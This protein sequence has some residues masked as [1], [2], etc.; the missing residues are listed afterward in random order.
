MREQKPLYS[1]D[2]DKE[3]L[4]AVKLIKEHCSKN[5]DCFKCIICNYPEYWEVNMTR[6][7][8]KQQM[9]IEDAIKVLTDTKCYGTMDIAKAVI[10][11]YVKEH[12][13]SEQERWRDGK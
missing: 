6:D 8:I 2:H 10:I 13:G 3:L 11:E 9:S 4:E 1:I 7:Q 5:K 12:K